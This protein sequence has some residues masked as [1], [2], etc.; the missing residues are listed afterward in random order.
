MP[1]SILVL[2]LQGTHT[3]LGRCTEL[4]KSKMHMSKVR[5]PNRLVCFTQC[6]HA[7]VLNYSQLL[8]KA[9]MKSYI[10]CCY[11]CLILQRQHYTKC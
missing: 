1:N 3:Y 11:N 2:S 7:S 6:D 10:Y 8:L 4:S 5:Y 9:N